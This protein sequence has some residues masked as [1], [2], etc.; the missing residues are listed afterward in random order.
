MF[1]KPYPR[2]SRSVVSCTEL[3]LAIFF[4]GLFKPGI[5]CAMAGTKGL[6]VTVKAC[7]VAGHRLHGQG[8]FHYAFITPCVRQT[9]RNVCYILAPHL[10]TKLEAYPLVRF[11]EW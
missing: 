2:C 9:Y 10:T 11:Y 5:D 7:Q 8:P 6:E 4:E 1:K 3:L